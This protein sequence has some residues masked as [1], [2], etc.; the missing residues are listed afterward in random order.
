MRCSP[1]LALARNVSEAYS[2][3]SPNGQ[4]AE[5]GIQPRGDYV[6]LLCE[7]RLVRLDLKAKPP[8][9]CT[10]SCLPAPGPSGHPASP[11]AER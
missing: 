11:S 8:G 2:F 6:S 10:A 4:Q 3:P 1:N 9:V 5:K 7:K